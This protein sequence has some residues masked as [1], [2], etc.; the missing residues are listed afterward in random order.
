MEK[1]KQDRLVYAQTVTLHVQNLQP[2]FN[3]TIGEQSSWMRPLI[4]QGF[5]KAE[6]YVLKCPIKLM[7]IW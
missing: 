2:T 4:P 5:S 1:F 3:L 7:F 6:N